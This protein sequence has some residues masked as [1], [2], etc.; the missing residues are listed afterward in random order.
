MKTMTEKRFQVENIPDGF[1]Y[2]PLLL[3]GLELYNPFVSLQAKRQ[4]VIKS[5]SK[6]LD[7]AFSRESERFKK[8]K[9]E[10][11]QRGPA[12][13]KA[14][15]EPVTSFMSFEEF[16][17]FRRER[18]APFY[19]AW[20]DLLDEAEEVAVEGTKELKGYLARLPDEQIVR[21]WNYL[22]WKYIR[23]AFGPEMIRVFGSL[24]VVE[25]GLLPMGLVKH[26]GGKIRW[27][28]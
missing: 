10:F 25:R 22:Y 2:F 5:A 17:K 20:S 27:S 7:R 24:S 11:D 23:E 13:P 21:G 8:L 3:G 1:I 4:G 6:A 16:T 9:E 12:R 14:L 19:D 15:P 26:W 28:G 18:S